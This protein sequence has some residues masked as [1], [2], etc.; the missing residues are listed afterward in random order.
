MSLEDLRNEL[1]RTEDTQQTALTF[2][3]FIEKKGDEQWADKLLQDLGPWLMVQLCDAA[4]FFEVLL[5]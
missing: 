3:E 2:T 4:N 1:K 5:K